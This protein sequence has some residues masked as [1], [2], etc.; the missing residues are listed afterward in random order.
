MAGC[1]CITDTHT[2]QLNHPP[3]LESATTTYDSNGHEYLDDDIKG[4]ME[5]GAQIGEKFHSQKR[6]VIVTGPD[7]PDDDDRD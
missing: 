4:V 1:K 7:N 2:T 6:D 5:W 3:P